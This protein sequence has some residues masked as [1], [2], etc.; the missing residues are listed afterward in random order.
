MTYFSAWTICGR[1]VAPSVSETGVSTSRMFAFGA[2]VWAYSTSSDV[3]LAQLSMSE[4]AGSNGGTAPAGWMIVNDG[5][6]GSPN[7]ASKKARAPRIVGE[8]KESTIT[9]VVPLPDIPRL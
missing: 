7:V 2:I 4:L 6:A 5:G 1:P 3:S 9:I 8:P